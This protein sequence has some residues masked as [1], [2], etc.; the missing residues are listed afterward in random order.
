MS[1][2]S[3][4][5]N[6]HKKWMYAVVWLLLAYYL[7]KMYQIALQRSDIIFSP[8]YGF[9]IFYTFKE[10][11]ISP[12]ANVFKNVLYMVGLF[13]PVGFL[14]P[15]ARNRRCQSAV[16]LITQLI[17]T[18]LE[19]LK[20]YHQKGI[21]CLEDFILAMLGAF[22]GYWIFIA[23]V[24]KTVDGYYYRNK[25]GDTK[26]GWLLY[27]VLVILGFAFLWNIAN[28]NIKSE[29]IAT[30]LKDV[31]TSGDSTE[32]KAGSRSRAE[33]IY[34]TIYEQIA[35]GKTRIKVTSFLGDVSSDDIENIF[36]QVLK[37]HPEIFW[38]SGSYYGMGSSV[39][40]ST[41][42]TLNLDTNCDISNLPQMQKN[43]DKVVDGIVKEAQKL[44]TDYDKV[45][46]VH[47]TI[48]GL[49]QYDVDSYRILQN[50][51]NIYV[52]GLTYS[53]YGC[54]VDNRAVCAGYSK[55]FQ[56]VMQKL[57]I[58]CG[59]VTGT[60]YNLQGSDLHAWNYVRI[61]NEYKYLDLTWDDPVSLGGSSNSL[62]HD[63]FCL[64]KDKM[65]MDHFADSD[66]Y[67]PE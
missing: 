23:L 4:F 61:D 44:T 46:Y 62:S 1:S 28:G 17:V 26:K 7:F 35:E 3:P 34:D 58:E 50:Q 39:I 54:L 27:L 18:A 66:Q 63:Y 59:Y 5:P 53:A 65:S 24:T 43:L 11:V 12:N 2:I 45:R 16:L 49:C 38:L 48:I 40:V 30:G 60:A 33:E 42:Y 20:Y 32:G 37:D 8:E 67:L 19:F 57:G 22:V 64:S 36:K 47:D 15:L 21:I 14:F 29:K 55:A 9:R 10:I 51:E 6:K 25:S 13:I 41:S 56:L 31:N 52:S